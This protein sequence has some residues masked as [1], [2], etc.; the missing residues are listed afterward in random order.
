MNDDRSRVA[1]CSGAAYPGDHVTCGFDRARYAVMVPVYVDEEVSGAERFLNGRFGQLLSAWQDLGRSPDQLGTSVFV[2]PG[3][4]VEECEPPGAYLVGFGR[5][6]TSTVA[7]QVRRSAVRSSIVL[8]LYPPVVPD[9][10]EASRPTRSNGSWSESRARC[11]EFATTRASGWRTRSPAFWKRSTT[12]TTT[13]PILSQRGLTCRVRIGHV[14]FVERYADRANL[15]ATAIRHISAAG[16]LATR[17]EGLDEIRVKSGDGDGRS[18][19]RGQ[20]E[21]RTV[22]VEAR[23]D[24]HQVRP[25]WLALVDILAGLDEHRGAELVGVPAEVL[26]GT[27][28]LAELSV[29]EALGSR[30]LLID[31]DGNHHGVAGPVEPTVQHGHLDTRHPNIACHPPADRRSCVHLT[32]FR[33][34]VADYRFRTGQMRFCRVV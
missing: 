14:E 22:E 8:R 16:D 10:A 34:S 26:P 4:D 1:R 17:F 5:A 28:Q 3:E 18:S 20:P 11:W 23:P 6:S 15:A 19:D 32:A 25:W 9:F 30:H 24:P 31:V 12:R 13:W 29:E 33:L 27:R 7:A 2:E 21:P